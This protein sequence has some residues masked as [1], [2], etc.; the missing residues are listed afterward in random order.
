MRGDR[1]CDLSDCLHLNEPT[2]PS[3]L[4]PLG[5]VADRARRDPDFRLVH[6]RNSKAASGTSQ[7]I[8]VASG[9]THGAATPVTVASP[10]ISLSTT[11]EH[12]KR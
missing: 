4:V 1:H 3:A 5:L 9:S 11:A 10:P 8:Q 12:S 6:S 2:Y 7:L